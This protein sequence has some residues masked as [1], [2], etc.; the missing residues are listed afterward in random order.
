MKLKRYTTL[1]LT[2]VVSLAAFSQNIEFVENKGQ[3]DSKV[4]FTGQF[5][6][7]AFYLHKNG[8]TIVHHHPDD[9]NQLRHAAHG[10]EQR[11]NATQVGANGITLRSHAYNVTFS[12]AN[13]QAQVLP[14]K[15]LT[16]KNNYF[17]GNDPKK[18]A[19]NCGVYN[20]VTIKN[21]YAG[22]DVR[23]YSNNG[24]LK[25]DIIVHPGG[26]AAAIALQYRG[27]NGLK[28]KNKELVISTSVGDLK[29]LL[30]STYQYLE[31]G[32]T[33]IKA[34]YAVTNNTVKF[35]LG[36]Y[37]ASR[38][39]IIDPTPIFV[40]FSGSTADNW[41]FTATYGPDGSLFGGGIVFSEGFPTNVG[42]FQKNY[43]GGKTG[44][45]M[46]GFDIGIIKFSPD[47][48][49]RLYATYIGGSGNEMPSSLIADN[50][51]N[52]VIAGR[53]TSINYPVSQ[54]AVGKGGGWD[55]VLTK[56]NASG[57]AIINSVKI[58]GSKDDGANITPCGG[59]G[60]SLQ[61]NYGDESRGEVNLDAAGN[62]WMA[63][64]TQSSDFPVIGGFQ[65]S[66][67]GGLQD[68][69]VL[70][71]SPDL[72]TTLVSSYFGGDGNDAAYVID[73]SPTTGYTYIAGGTESTNLPGPT[74]GTISPTN[75][76]STIDGFVSIIDAN[77]SAVLKTTYLGTTGIDQV[78]GLKFD[79]FGYPYVMGQ[80][81]GKWPVL[82][83]AWSQPN[84]RQ[85]ISKM[86]PDLSAFAYSTT[87]G[88][89][90]AS[91]DISPVAFL[92]DR[93][94][95][96]YVSGWGGYSSQTYKNA[97][98][99]G[100]PVTADAIKSK[101]DINPVSRQG[102]DF[103]FFVLEKNAKS[104][105]YGS[106]FGQDGGVVG[107]HVDGGTSRFDRN[108]VIYQA[109]CASCGNTMPFPT[110]PG[111][112]ATTKPPAA[113]CNLAVVKIAF[114]FSGVA[115]GVQSSI[116]GVPRD[117][118]GC[119]PLTVDFTDTLKSGVQFEWNFGDGSPSVITTTPN[120][121]HT[122]TT[123]GVYNVRLIAIDSS[124]C[125]ERDTSYINIRVGDNEA[126]LAFTSKKLEPCTSFQYQFS[127]VSSPNPG[128][129]FTPNAFVWDFGDGTPRVPAG[130][131]D[132]FHTYAAPGTYNVRLIL[133]DSNFCNAPDSITTQLRVAELVKANFET[134]LTGC[135]PYNA[136]FTN[137]SAGGSG[138]FWDFGDGGT[139]T[140]MSPTH[141]YSLPGTYTISLTVVDSATCN[142]TDVKTA[143]ITVLNKAVADF[144]VAPQ[145]PSENQPLVFTNLSSAEAVSFKWLFGDGDSLITSS[146]APVSHEYN[147]TGTY[148]AC[149]V[150]M[151]R[152]GCADTVCK[153]VNTLVVPALDVPTA[154]TPA[155][156]D[157]NSKVFVRG[158][159]FA[160]MKFT[161]WARWGEKVF[162]T[163]DKRIG[164]DGKFKGKLLP[165]DVY[166]YTLSVEFTD[167]TKATKTG[168]ITLI[169]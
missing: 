37:D 87:F 76:G 60:A 93:C 158:F 16:S 146:R 56:L 35:N 86:Q 34:R 160:K 91:P 1:F 117:T 167:G 80:T 13:A 36:T 70:K 62:V 132:I 168:D 33:E 57:S 144:S 25:Y 21:M 135:A 124:T 128:Y 150:A 115:S 65:G 44:C 55:I 66:F 81:T 142:I 159:G 123:V 11:G 23:F 140:E 141:L 48:H 116:N 54:P 94:E 50:Q 71:F 5:T 148:N 90:E 136:V 163:N 49:N 133:Q 27:V 61:Q 22:V 30:P 51:G 108:G 43:A 107:D 26:N 138:F 95:N 47:G 74:A 166:T 145:P 64:C 40:S 12:N 169:R 96:V 109:I 100:L 15:A 154:F 89:G 99:Q 24:T 111:A 75:N 105:L 4:L 103:Y 68:G 32:K 97:G 41:G 8:F 58:G 20:G 112:W 134:P 88:K 3:W 38:P 59:G 63:S 121:S 78:F 157:N 122:Y 72:S 83:A 139:A 28:V 153:D 77:G 152:A 69:V 131:G 114:E 92:V 113:N 46:D 18:W 118:A 162:E 82:N 101:P 149:L 84:G 98:V 102:Q 6:G 53:T 52:L 67:G 119:V 106:F 19:S 156:G 165:M 104:Q 137:T 125:N 29:E 9:W 161:V 147:A 126:R 130:V 143:T 42:A 73:F 155:S 164:W 45:F 10:G 2:L 110:S 85:F 120:I 79:R 127:N 31:K 151:N 14:D 129:S 7:G 17:I 39:L